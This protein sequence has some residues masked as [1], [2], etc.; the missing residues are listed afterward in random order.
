MPR[1]LKQICSIFPR[2]DSVRL[3]VAYFRDTVPEEI[4]DLIEIRETKTGAKVKLESPP[5]AEKP[6]PLRRFLERAAHAC[7]QRAG[8]QKALES[9]LDMS[10]L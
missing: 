1:V 9:V 8:M 5:F 6:T 2:S 4:E 3:W 10:G 7:E